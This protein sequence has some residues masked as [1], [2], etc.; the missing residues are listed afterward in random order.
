MLVLEGIVSQHSREKDRPVAAD[1]GR[2]AAR[3]SK[4]S[5]SDDVTNPLRLETAAYADHASLD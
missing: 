3:P 1:L 4:R 2:F 5:G